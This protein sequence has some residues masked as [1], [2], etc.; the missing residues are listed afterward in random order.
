MKTFPHPKDEWGHTNYRK[1]IDRFE[2]IY[3]RK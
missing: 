2:S 1:Y 3:T